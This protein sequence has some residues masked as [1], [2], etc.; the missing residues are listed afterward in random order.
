[1]RLIRTKK[2]IE[3]EVQRKMNFRYVLG[4]V[5]LRGMVKVFSVSSPSFARKDNP[6]KSHSGA[7][8]SLMTKWDLKLVG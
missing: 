3:G 6:E 2:A 4:F 7:R 8:R 1:M 5:V